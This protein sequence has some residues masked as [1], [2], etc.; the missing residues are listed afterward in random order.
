M[1]STESPPLLPRTQSVDGSFTVDEALAYIGFGRFQV[2]LLVVL[3]MAW[4]ADS[5][6]ILVLA[7]LGPDASS[8]LR[9]H[10]ADPPFCVSRLS[11]NGD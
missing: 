8:P 5:T 10:S 2:I 9:P 1:S 3:G 11:V 4:F 6:E 7:F